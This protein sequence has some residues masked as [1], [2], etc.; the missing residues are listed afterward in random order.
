MPSE[1]L[2]KWVEAVPGDPLPH[3]L[4]TGCTTV[5]DATDSHEL[6]GTEWR[7]LSCADAHDTTWCPPGDPAPEVPEKEFARPGICSAPPVAIYAGAECST[8]G[9]SFAEA[10][11]QAAETLRMGEQRAL[12]EWFMREVLCVT[13]DDLTPAA[14]ALSIAQGVG[15]LESWLGTEYGG[16]GLLHVPVGAG[17]LLGDVVH[18]IDGSPQTLVGN[19]VIFG[20]GYAVNVGP[21]DCTP[22]DSGEAW[23]YATSPIRIRTEAPDDVPDEDRQS[24]DILTNDRRVLVERGFVVEI[25]CCSVAAVRVR[26]C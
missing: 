8:T 25:A 5:I 21:P 15:V 16:R 20:A 1:G 11:R 12:E 4:L 26:L 22:A 10:R 7:P 17:A 13:A 3:G 24:V 14:G 18:L 19:C 23:L 9:F 6:L 2:R